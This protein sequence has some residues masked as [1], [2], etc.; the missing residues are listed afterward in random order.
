MD[1]DI[2]KQNNSS[3]LLLIFGGWSTDPSFYS[4]IKPEGWDVVAITSYSDFNFPYEIL[5]QYSSAGIIAWSF[6]VYA[7]EKS[8]GNKKVAFAVA[9]NGTTRPINDEYGIPENIFS[10]TLSSLNQRNLLKFR[11]RTFGNAFPQVENL[12]PSDDNIDNLKKEL[13]FILNQSR[14][15][16]Q[17]SINPFFWTKAYISSD[18]RI[19]PPLAQEKA[20]KEFYPS[21]EILQ[22][23]GDHWID[24]NKIASS[25]LVPRPVIAKKFE[26]S[27]ARYDANAFAQREIAVKLTQ[28][29]PPSKCRRILEIGH[30]SGLFSR[31]IAEKLRPEIFDFIDLYRVEPFNIAPQENYIT[32][33]AEQILK[34]LVLNH[35]FEKQSDKEDVPLYD[36]IVSSSA[37]QWFADPAKF[38]DNCFKLLKPGGFL[39]FSTF[40]HNNLKELTRLNPFRILYRSRSEIEYYLLKIFGNVKSEEDIIRLDFDSGRKA[41]LHLALTGVGSTGNQRSHSSED[42]P[43]PTA[44]TFYPLFFLSYKS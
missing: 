5:D 13:E 21:T 32:G 31:M 39:L 9:V 1:F 37:V 17:S 4:H 36:A 28:M 15:S 38:F 33:D 25:I 26:K 2:I 22:I 41:L 44:L 16:S 18:D 34:D 12:L 8:I 43:A 42:L 30:G 7:A 27:L 11:K 6:G 14:L 3:N 29:A 23:K 20:W 35:E 10:G 19:F 40:S 24:L